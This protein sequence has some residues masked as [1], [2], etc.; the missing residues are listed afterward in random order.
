MVDES[1]KPLRL[2]EQF[3]THK[4]LSTKTHPHPH[5]IG[6]VLS[7]KQNPQ[8]SKVISTHQLVSRQIKDELKQLDQEN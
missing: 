6:Y 3:H 5:P 1:S 2:W 7:C 4:F 8:D